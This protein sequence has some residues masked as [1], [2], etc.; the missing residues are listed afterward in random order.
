MSFKRTLAVL[1]AAAMLSTNGAC[2]PAWA[3]EVEEVVETQPETPR[4]EAQDAPAEAPQESP[5]EEPKEAP[6]EESPKEAPR[7]EAATEEAPKEEPKQEEPK[8]EAPKEEPKQEAPTEEPKEEPKQ[9]AP[10]EEPKEEPK[11][12]AT[13]EE[14]KE[15]PSQTPVQETPQEEPSAEQTPAEEPGS[16]GPV[17]SATES[18]TEAPV[19]SET[20]DGGESQP[21]GSR[22]SATET[23]TEA[24]DAA[25][26][27]PTEVAPIVTSV[28]EPAEIAS[29]S[30]AKSSVIMGESVLFSFSVRH[31]VR[32]RYSLVDPSGSASTGS[33]TS[34]ADHF[35]FTAAKEGRYA[36]ELTATGASG[37]EV[38]ASASV[39]VI[40]AP[41]LSLS[42]KANAPSCHGGDPVSFTLSVTDGLELSSAAI[43]ASLGGKVFFTADEFTRE[44]TVTPPARGR[45]SDLSVTL[46]VTDVFGRTAEKSATIPCAVHDEETRAAWEATM[47]GVQKTGVWPEDLLAIARTQI[48]YKESSRDFG[49]KYDGGLSGYTRYGDW[50]GLPYEEWCAMFAGFCLHYAGIDEKDFPYASNCQRWINALK[51]VGLY[52]KSGDYIPKVGDLVFFDWQNDNDSDHVGIIFE[53]DTDEDGNVLG[54]RT[55]EGN[56]KGA[57]VYDGKY[58]KI[59]DWTVIGYGLVN[60]A[61]DRQI[62]KQHRDLS[63]EYEGFSI[64]AGV[65]P[66]AKIP[67]H[68]ELDV[69][70][71]L[72]DDENYDRM[73]GELR[74]AITE[75][76]LGYARFLQVGF[77]DE[78]GAEVTAQ[79]PVTMTV[80]FD[81]KM[82]G[83]KDFVPG[84]AAMGDEVTV[85]SDVTLERAKQ[86]CAFSFTQDVGEPLCLFA[87]GTLSYGEGTLKAKQGKQSASAAYTAEAMIPDGAELDFHEIEPDTE[88]YDACV[89]MMGEAMPEGDDIVANAAAVRFFAVNITFNGVPVRPA[90]P[91]AVTLDADQ[92]ADEAELVRVKDGAALVC[93]TSTRKGGRLV[94]DYNADRF[95]T[96]AV[97]YAEK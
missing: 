86:S 22:D 68:A 45:V 79:A 72:P 55:I 64:A 27:A 9:E 39:N 58:Y 51:K 30:A 93:Q 12:E 1:L 73:L 18:P 76:E 35:A 8:Q 37:A 56:S 77:V 91:V 49:P 48:G 57:A 52:A 60:R 5:K 17:E 83:D 67:A 62:E 4:A 50:A 38:S 41:A 96:F 13:T 85:N 28:P 81:G 53:L 21:D 43:K 33:L 65:E 63:A 20:P 71:I 7:Q 75:G 6:R 42:V 32:L 61:Y 26:P 78:D 16:E 36:F 23:P 89:A 3:D 92:K 34:E 59:D 44:L 95:G 74:G 54:I 82:V 14:P 97:I 80:T 19:H 15:E 2:I 94:V 87:A 84:V 11:Q 40:N 31:A 90:V 10:T 70:E 66:E 29:L 46:S 88:A 24:P 69:K 25:T 47:K